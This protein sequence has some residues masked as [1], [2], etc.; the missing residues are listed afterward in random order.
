MPSKKPAFLKTLMSCS[1]VTLLSSP[2]LVSAAPEPEATSGWS[3]SGHVANLNVDSKAAQEQHVE[4]SAFVFGF[5]AERYSNT[6]MFTF[7]VGVDF[8]AYD[9]QRSF[10]Q[11]T[12]GGVKDSDASAILAYVEYGPR[13]VFGSD[14]ANYVT[15]HAGF[16]GI[17]ASS[18]GIGYCTNCNSEDINLDGGAYG[19]LGIGHSFTSFDIGLQFQQYFTGDL[20]NSLRLRF[21]SKF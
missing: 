13:F 19:S 10:S 18:R 21:S 14:K 5:A 16:S 1:L 11:N 3:W 2:L 6:N 7:T 20:D 12:T 17:F 4:D 15:A 8:I 9:D